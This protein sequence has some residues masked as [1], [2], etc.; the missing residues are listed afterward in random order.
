MTIW[1]QSI[2]FDPVADS[3]DYLAAFFDTFFESD[4]ESEGLA[5]HYRKSG[6]IE[7]SFDS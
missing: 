6:P 1:V 4:F 2:F 5:I 3:V 7:G